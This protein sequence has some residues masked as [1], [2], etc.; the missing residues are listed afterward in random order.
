MWTADL[1]HNILRHWHSPPFVVHLTHKYHPEIS[2]LGVINVCVQLALPGGHAFLCLRKAIR[3]NENLLFFYY[4]RV[5]PD[6]DYYTTHMSYICHNPDIAVTIT[7]EQQIINKH[8]W[9]IKQ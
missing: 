1:G 5:E 4:S 7:P 9:K 8:L 6:E 3:K 2:I